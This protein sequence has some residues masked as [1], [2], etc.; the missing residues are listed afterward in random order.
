[1]ASDRRRRPANLRQALEI[2]VGDGF[3][4]CRMWASG[5]VGYLPAREKKPARVSGRAHR[6]PS[7]T[8][9]SRCLLQVAQPRDWGIVFGRSSAAPH[10]A[11][12]RS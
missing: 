1:M 6:H 7:C 10:S 9:R 12:E 5:R 4:G 8:R 3:H 11:H 2:D